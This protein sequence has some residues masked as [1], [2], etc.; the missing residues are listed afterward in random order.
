MAQIALHDY[1][2]QINRFLEDERPTD[3]IIHSRHLLQQCPRHV[4]T[5]R[6]LA[7][8]L[9]EHR[10]FENAAELFQRILSAD[11][12]DFVAHIGLSDIYRESGQLPEALWHMERAYEMSPY[13]AALQEVLREL[14]F[15]RDNE[16]PDEMPLTR[17]ALAR[18][19]FNGELY[20]QA[21]DELRAILGK[22]GNDRVDLQ[23]LLAETLWR[24][25][26]RVDA[27]DVSL[28]VLEKLPDSIT[29]NAI[30]GEIWLLTGR[31]EEAQVYLQHLHSLTQV[32][33]EHLDPDSVV[34][35]AFQADGAPVLPQT[36][37]VEQWR[38]ADDVDK[39]D[40][41]TR[42]GTEQP[43]EDDAVYDWLRDTTD[44]GQLLA[45][46]E[47]EEDEA[48]W[49]TDR[50]EEP[51]GQEESF[52]KTAEWLEGIGVEPEEGADF[53]FTE[54]G[55]LFEDDAPFKVDDSLA[56]IESEPGFSSEPV[57][58]LPDWLDDL[59]SSSELQAEVLE[60]QESDWFTGTLEE[61][62]TTVDAELLNTDELLSDSAN[63]D[64]DWLAEQSRTDPE[65]T[66]RFEDEVADQQDADDESDWFTADLDDG[67]TGETADSEL[68][69]T[70]DLFSEEPEADFDWLVE[71][72]SQTELE[73]TGA[74]EEKNQE[75]DEFPDWLTTP[76]DESEAPESA[77]AEILNTDELLTNTAETDFDWLI[78]DEPQAQPDLDMPSMD[79]GQVQD[80]D[81]DDIDDIEEQPDW[82]STLDDTDAVQSTSDSGQLSTGD[83]L[84]D[85]SEADFDWL[86][87]STSEAEPEVN[88]QIASEVTSEIGEF[89]D[90]LTELE[91]SSAT[92]DLQSVEPTNLSESELV[93]TGDLFAS[94]DLNLLTDNLEEDQ[95]SPLIQPTS[96]V[97]EMNTDELFA[98]VLDEM[99]DWLNEDESQAEESPT[100]ELLSNLLNTHE[101]FGDDDIND[102]PDWIEDANYDE[103]E[104]PL[105]SGLIRRMNRMMGTDELFDDHLEEEEYVF[106]GFDE[107]DSIPKGF[108]GLLIG[109]G[110][111]A[112]DVIEDD[113]D[114][115][116]TS[117]DEG[118]TSLPETAASGMIGLLGTAEL[119]ADLGEDV[120][121]WLVGDNQDENDS[122][123]PT[124]QTADLQGEKLEDVPHF[125]YSE[126]DEPEESLE[127]EEPK[128]P[129]SGV[130]GTAELF[131]SLGEEVPDWIA[132]LSDEEGEEVPSGHAS[133][134]IGTDALLSELDTELP[135]WADTAAD[136]TDSQS[137]S[138]NIEAISDND[139]LDKLD[140]GEEAV[141]EA[142]Q[143][144]KSLLDWLS[145]QPEANP[146]LQPSEA[147]EDEFPDWLLES[148]NEEQ[149][150]AVIMADNENEFDM[151]DMPDDSDSLDWLNELASEADS[152]DKGK[153]VP[154]KADEGTS[155]WLSELT[156]PATE[157]EAALSATD[158]DL[159]LTLTDT[160]LPDWLKDLSDTSPSSPAQPAIAGSMDNLPDWLK[161]P[162]DLDL[163]LGSSPEQAE[164]EELLANVTD[165][166][167]D[168]LDWLSDVA[169]DAQAES[170]DFAD[171]DADSS[172]DSSDVWLD[173]LAESDLDIVSDTADDSFL[174]DIPNEQVDA[175]DWLSL[176]DETSEELLATADSLQDDDLSDLFTQPIAGEEIGFTDLIS[177]LEA[178]QTDDALDWLAAVEDGTGA[179][180]DGLETTDDETIPSG[181]V[182]TAEFLAM[183][184]DADGEEEIVWETADDGDDLP[185]DPVETTEFLAMF[186]DADGEEEIVW[187]TADD[188]D[189]LPS[190][191]VETA[192]F[193][194]MFD[195]A[196]GEEE[197]VWETADDGDDLPSGPVETAE[198][199]AMFDDAD[200]EGLGWETDDD[201]EALPSR[202]PVETSEFLA[203]FDDVDS[204]DAL[205]V[206]AAEFT[207]DTPDWLTVS[208]AEESDVD[209]EAAV[210]DSDATDD[211]LDLFADPQTDM[212][213]FDALEDSP[214][215]TP[216]D[217]PSSS[218]EEDAVAIAAQDDYE[219]LDLA[220]DNV[221]DWLSELAADETDTGE[222]D[223]L[224]SWLT[225]TTGTD[226][227]EFADIL[228]D[229][230]EQ[231]DLD[232]FGEGDE[233]SA[234]TFEEMSAAYDDDSDEELP[235]WLQAVAGS[236]AE[237]IV[238]ETGKEIEVDEIDALTELGIDTEDEGDFEDPMAWLDNLASEQ[239]D[240]VDELPSI[241][242]TSMY[243][244]LDEVEATDLEASLEIPDD[245]EAALD[246]LEA[247]AEEQESVLEEETSLPTDLETMSDP[248]L[249][250][251]LTLDGSEEDVSEFASDLLADDELDEADALSWLDALDDE[252]DVDL[253]DL[254]T[255]V[256]ET[257]D[258][259]LLDHVEVDEPAPDMADLAVASLSV[260]DDE[261]AMSWLDALDESDVSL[262]DDL[263]TAVPDSE[264]LL[265]AVDV[266]DDLEEAMA[267]LDN[268]EA[269]DDEEQFEELPTLDESY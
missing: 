234:F 8:A 137:H 267:W 131:A 157:S 32:D 186:D 124:L 247:L 182:E 116:V 29:V 122:D 155:D 251:M 258:D 248:D 224:P 235:E 163:G 156:E 59:D 104:A 245:P 49:F 85:T 112:E 44:T 45:S 67:E 82:L 134:L 252:E 86:V 236:E 121:D 20:Q 162:P 149:R 164:P 238:D 129:H 246:L 223:E 176:T 89:P 154:E 58:A 14:Y 99:P 62:A 98:G 101:L 39:L 95:D 199:L 227:S 203:M 54:D 30:L 51:P 111:L 50:L 36:I 226:T 212:F 206:S 15:Q 21:A 159:P 178:T 10:E 57:D 40:S 237:P 229:A 102:V 113:D 138:A 142:P 25:N 171:A 144:T 27:V 81:D 80:D 52:A 136:K 181:P 87:E 145:G 179:D 60:D 167:D 126:E 230:G 198:F 96:G 7:R 107:P 84:S 215:G 83:L 262:G 222:E 192:E 120:P 193:L 91:D 180:W 190:D 263:E 34:G 158:D 217:E 177:D 261:P 64:F 3:A 127:P 196:D 5:Y 41:G 256:E 123:T 202:E 166:N 260:S 231:D 201:S 200:G 117:P 26:Q 118:T 139:Q 93:G 209:F 72:I 110:D 11:P 255:R 1:L 197:I 78:D 189:D 188:G 90:W 73:L 214:I 240:T 232:L 243:D 152:S 216:L 17:A 241:L 210:F 47:D 70:G 4:D 194:A 148:G 109:T 75:A 172:T 16:V 239:A 65:M 250:D 160:D 220:D 133:G 191:P 183:F 12:N 68:I 79:E 119:L 174:D 63:I 268:L 46:L 106:E 23:V 173:A 31:T 71:N 187:E 269:D 2:E 169:E 114:E 132:G 233:E 22:N 94:E 55:S 257:A 218:I 143:S 108:T 33:Q 184:D 53:D 92:S 168:A 38:K 6:L 170:F 185:S 105:E 151:N 42:V 18:L 228:A 100:G 76:S 13:D 141:E 225:G 195:D 130:I 66:I 28:K 254:P 165:V 204:S 48:D 266:P 219:E 150:E 74:D 61:E 56:W 264:D 128:L 69:S 146:E 244:A 147:N 153:K 103:D 265:E 135:D 88:E 221:S 175:P 207:D 77:S 35:H 205:D 242:D 43:I 249:L 37:S 253:G 24:N 208:A 125:L 213:A 9:L 19:Y 97:S 161:P 140:M 211:V 115:P 259:L